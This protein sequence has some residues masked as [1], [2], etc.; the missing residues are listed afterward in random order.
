MLS[1]VWLLE[2]VHAVGPWWDEIVEGAAQTR[3][4]RR[5]NVSGRPTTALQH[6]KHERHADS[7]ARFGHARR[8]ISTKLPME[9]SER[10]NEPY[11]QGYFHRTRF[12]GFVR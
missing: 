9:S 1:A 2:V 5:R 3:H 12:A 6:D 4:V 8:F 10:G 11:G 7:T